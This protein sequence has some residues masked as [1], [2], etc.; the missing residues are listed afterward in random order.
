MI[1]SSRSY[2]P[3][4]GRQQRPDRLVHDRAELVSVLSHAASRG[5]DVNIRL[6]RDIRLD[7]GIT[8]PNGVGSLLVHGGGAFSFVF[9]ANLASVFSL[10]AGA[11]TFVDVGFRAGSA[12]TA[13]ALFTHRS[14]SAHL[15]LGLRG[16]SV[17]NTTDLLD[18]AK[19]WD[20]GSAVQ[21]EFNATGPL[22]SA[23]LNIRDTNGVGAIT[24]WIFA[25]CIG[26]FNVDLNSLSQA[27]YFNRC[28]SAYNLGT[29]DTTGGGAVVAGNRH[30]LS[31]CTFSSYAVRNGD[32]VFPADDLSGTHACITRLPAGIS[33]RPQS[34]TL[35]SADPTLDPKGS[36]LVRFTLG[37][38]ASGD[39]YVAD[40]VHDGQVLILWCASITGTGTLQ[41]NTTTSNCRLT[42][43]WVPGVRDSI[44]LFWDASDGN[45]QELARS[46][47]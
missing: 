38:S 14:G 20:E 33:F 37:A 13:T 26:N 27:V 39:I 12:V 4:E 22:G 8:V 47:T 35:N 3:R 31:G 24:G 34:L 17:R 29:V 11:A 40:G 16:V 25:D 30:V 36:S 41:D 9:T 19:Q 32:A 6:A 10:H 18:P 45:W 5:D 2:S 7:A 43:A 46:D 28:G 44:T 15:F 21:C 1:G 23:N 42:A